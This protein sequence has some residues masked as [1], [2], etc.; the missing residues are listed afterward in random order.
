MTILTERDGFAFALLEVKDVDDVVELIAQGF[1][2]GSEPTALA[3]GLGPENLKQFVEALLPKFLGEGLS[4]VARD[5]HTG[6]IVGA[7][8][9]DEV[10]MDLP[11][12]PSQFEWAVP[13]LAM[14]GD[15]YGRYFQGQPPQPGESFHIFIIGVSRSFRG[16][17]IGQRL[18]DLSLGLARGRGY[19]KA[20]VEASGIIS[21]HIFRKAGFTTRVEIPYATFEYEGKRPFANTGTHPSMMLMDKSL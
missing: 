2:D 6:E 9:N 15:V 1:T 4:I 17:D 7:Q 21:Q 20:V 14:A 10:S 12:E 5:A 18:I 19:K 16:K 3:L 11:I 13:I 8:L